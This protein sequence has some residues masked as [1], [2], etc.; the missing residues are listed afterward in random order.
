MYE[1]EQR[2]LN[3][4]HDAFV[5][6]LQTVNVQFEKLLEQLVTALMQLVLCVPNH[7]EAFQ[8]FV[9]ALALRRNHQALNAV[10]LTEEVEFVK[11][12]LLV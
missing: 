2:L 12:L 9:R 10:I 6:I 1:Y 8:S 11:D 5:L 4:D 7:L 3:S